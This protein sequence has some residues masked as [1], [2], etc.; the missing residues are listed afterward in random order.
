ML[1]LIPMQ[2][3]EFEPFMALS[4]QE[5]AQGHVKEGRWKAE[6]AEANIRKMREQLL[7]EGLN[8][9]GHF[10]YTLVAE[11]SDQPVGTLWFTLNEHDGEKSLFVMDIQIASEHRRKGYGTEAFKLMENKAREM[12]IKTITLHVFRENAPAQA[13]YRKLGYSGSDDRMEK[14]L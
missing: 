2:A 7:P 14:K 12:G 8:T 11:D 10:F 4:M 6:E 9:P 3:T 5:Q 13:M 1:K